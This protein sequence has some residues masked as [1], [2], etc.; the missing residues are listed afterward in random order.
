MDKVAKP[1]T[2]HGKQYWEIDGQNYM[3]V[4][5]R[6]I[7]VDRFEEDGTPVCSS[8]WSEE[9]PNAAGG[10][11]CTVHVECFEIASEHHRPG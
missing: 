1:V 8:T 9:T 11:D 7:R 2:L 4:G 6:L 5:N 3:Q 10:Q